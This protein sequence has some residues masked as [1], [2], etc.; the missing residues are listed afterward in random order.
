M[1]TAQKAKPFTSVL[2]FHDDGF[3]GWAHGAVYVGNREYHYETKHFEEG[4]QFGID[5]GRVSKLRIVR[6]FPNRNGHEVC[7]YDR[8]GDVRPRK[9]NAADMAAY[10]AVLK[11]YN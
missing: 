4:S 1:K 2:Q 8:G 9:T 5:N 11:K 6:V 10:N 7:A 3:G